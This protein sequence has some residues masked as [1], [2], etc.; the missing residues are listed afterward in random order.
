MIFV[1]CF[2]F[3]CFVIIVLLCFFLSSPLY[4]SSIQVSGG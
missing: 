2:V 3:V 4:S 1:G